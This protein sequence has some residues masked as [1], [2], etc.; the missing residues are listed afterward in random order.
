MG[1]LRG[2]LAG[3][4]VVVTGA[5]GGIGRAL[6]IG[7]SRDGATVVGVGRRT[8]AL[9]ETARRCP[10][11]MTWV[12]ADLSR[13][14]ECARAVDGAVT[15]HGQVDVLINN[16]GTAAT[17]PFLETP[18]DRWTAVVALN[19]LGV[20]ACS[21]AALPHMIRREKGRIVTLTSRMAGTRIPGNSAYSASKAGASA[22]TRSLA[23]EV[24]SAHPNVLINDLIPGLTKTEMSDQGQDPESVYPFARRLVLL[25]AGGP[26]GHVFFR[27]DPFELFC[28]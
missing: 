17:G 1:G 14:E 9:E 22:L 7:F 13:P 15:D 2:E 10:G 4:V 25:P 21:R 20:A 18:F 19:L 28:T 12:S 3:E 6:A 26:S 23:A 16:A 5:G 24:T 8:A 11:S 27:D